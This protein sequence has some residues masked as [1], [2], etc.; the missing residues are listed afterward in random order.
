MDERWVSR[1]Q[2]V[3]TRAIVAADEGFDQA[4]NVNLEGRVA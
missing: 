2:Q 4:P 1:G 3:T